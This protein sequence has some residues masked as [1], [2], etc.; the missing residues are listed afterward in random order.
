MNRVEASFSQNY[1]LKL[2]NDIFSL[3]KAGLTLS[4]KKRLHDAKETLD[5]RLAHRERRAE[6]TGINYI[7][8]PIQEQEILQCS[9]GHDYEYAISNE[10]CL[11]KLFPIIQE[12][13]GGIVAIGSDQGLDLFANSKATHLFMIDIAQDTSLLTRTLLEVGSRHKKTFGAYPT[14]KQYIE[15]FEDD[16]LCHIVRFLKEN[17]HEDKVKRIVNLL[18]VGRYGAG[19]RIMYSEY[20]SYKAQ[21]R[22]D[23][24]QRFGWC[25]SKESLE[26]IFRAYD[27]GRIF[28]IKGD[29]GSEELIDRISSLAYKR[30]I[31]ISILYLSNSEEYREREVLTHSL[32][33][34]LSLP[35]DTEAVVLRTTHGTKEGAFF[36]KEDTVP[37]K[38]RDLFNPWHYIGQKI[39]DFKKT[40]EEQNADLFHYLPAQV[41]LRSIGKTLFHPECGVTFLG[42]KENE[43]RGKIYVKEFD[44]NYGTSL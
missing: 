13:R 26:R 14:P 41:T 18:T 34:T 10:P 7:S 44:S 27:E 15:Y 17:L 9:A 43:L 32:K 21:V 19:Y 39:E 1:R 42:F 30:N 23:Q 36:K 28:V 5:Y 20:L 35:F 11:H 3:R 6:K 31:S 24:G 38:I 33:T 25:A 4:A 22:N 37:P 8:K 40:V 29:I 2:A 12:K 16:N